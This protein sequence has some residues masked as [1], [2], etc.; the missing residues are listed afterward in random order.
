MG[1]IVF[2]VS[3]ACPVPAQ[4]SLV[5]TNGDWPPYFSPQFKYGGFGSRIVTEAFAQA[6]IDVH[7]EYLPWKRAYESAKAGKFAG[8][9]G[10]R[11]TPQR[12]KYF[13]FSDPILTQN[14]V[15]FHKRGKHF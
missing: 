13:Y 12:E 4:E 5:L 6:G 9:V 7:Y 8:S 14:A 11:K 1:A 10:W 2:L 3:S 15:F